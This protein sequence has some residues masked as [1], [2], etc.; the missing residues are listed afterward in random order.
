MEEEGPTGAKVS[1]SSADVAIVCRK[2]R[3]N[4]QMVSP[5]TQNTVKV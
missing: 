5:T 3:P 2:I 1:L 4:P